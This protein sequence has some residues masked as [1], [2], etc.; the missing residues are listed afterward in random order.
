MKSFSPQQIKKAAQ[1]LSD[2][3]RKGETPYL[4]SIEDRHAYLVT[5]LPATQAALRRV[6]KEIQ[7]GKI[8]S[9]LDIGAGPGASWDV[10]KE[11]WPSLHEA[12]FVELDM[13][14]VK[15]G[16]EQL[17]GQPIT[18]KLQSAAQLGEIPMHDLVLFSYSWGEI[19]S[20][21]ALH[22]AWDRCLQ[23]LVIVEPGT[24]RGYEAMLEARDALIKKGGSVVAPCPHSQICPWQGSSE[25]CHF[26]TR[27]ERSRDHQWMKEGNLG[28]EDEKFSYI[29]ISRSNPAPFLGRMVK[30]SLRRKGHTLLTLCTEQGIVTKTVSKK[31]KQLF[32]AINKIE[33]GDKI[34]DNI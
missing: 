15:I 29:I 32:K 14:F 13:E 7:D 31:N 4:R 24:P 27:L 12:T 17:Q 23:Y 6:L 30:D 25:W 18:W 10:A 11:I 22:H 3:Y 8:T 19:K 2:R 21:A 28:Y 1:A 9:Y 20:L 33:W 5:R 16:K 26:A 34:I